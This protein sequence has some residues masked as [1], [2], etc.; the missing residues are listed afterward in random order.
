MKSTL[1][2][3]QTARLLD[4]AAEAYPESEFVPSV[5]EWYEEHG[6]I[7]EN[8]EAALNSIIRKSE[9]RRSWRDD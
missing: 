2:P 7:T 9:E 6:F 4:E 1:T 3:D 5:E 8:Q